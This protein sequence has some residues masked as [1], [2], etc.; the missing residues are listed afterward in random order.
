MRSPYPVVIAQTPTA[1]NSYTPVFRLADGIPPFAPVLV[2][3]GI[4]SIPGNV[5]TTTIPNGFFRRGYIESFNFTVQKQLPDNFSLQASY[6][7][8]RGIRVAGLLE[9]NPG[10]IPGAGAAGQPLNVLF[11][12]TAGTGIDEPAGGTTNYNSRQARLDHRFAAGLMVLVSYTYSKSIDWFSDSGGSLLFLVPSAYARN[13]A[14]S[15]FDRTQNLEIGSTWEL[16]FGKGKPWLKTSKWCVIAC[17]WQLSAQISSYTG[18]PFTVG[19]SSASLNA[20]SSSQVADQV[21]GSVAITGGIGAGHLYFDPNAFQAVTQARFG[22]AGRNSMRGPGLTNAN[23]SLFRTV[24]RSDRGEQ[25]CARKVTTSPTRRISDCRVRPW[26][27][28]PSE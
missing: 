7:G 16:P 19:A 11:G 14:V 26:D 22:N 17:G 3:N 10:L 12:R 8:T 1:P 4:I 5:A 21:L 15:N 25:I 27:R 20:P 2:G 13:R 6:V 9:G 28:V 24:Y 18:L 23:L